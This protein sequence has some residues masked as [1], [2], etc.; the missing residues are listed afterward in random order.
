MDMDI[1]EIKLENPYEEPVI[2]IIPL[3]N[4]VLSFA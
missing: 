2:N 1:K 3:L 4:R